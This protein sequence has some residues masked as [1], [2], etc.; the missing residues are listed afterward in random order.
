M[1]HRIDILEPNRVSNGRGGFKTPDGE[2]PWRLLASRVFAE[3]IAL[4]GDEAVRNSIE[5]SVQLWR[6]TIRPRAGVAPTHRLV[7]N[8]IAMDIKS[9]APNLAGDELV[10]TC[11]SGANGR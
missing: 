9:A 4:R 6:V 5:R 8:G 2:D 1:R 11:E 7:W 10:M 3:V